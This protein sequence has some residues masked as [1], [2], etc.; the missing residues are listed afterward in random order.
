[1]S[2][3]SFLGRAYHRAR[4][5]CAHLSIDIWRHLTGRD[6]APAVAGFLVPGATPA[7]LGHAAGVTV[8]P[9]P[10]DPC[11]VLMRS[12]TREPHVAVFHRGR[13][14]HF[15]NNRRV[16]YQPLEVVTFGYSKVR[17]FTC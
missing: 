1:V 10:V 16:Q 3:D 17:F 9:R 11:F 14:M 2:L 7:L 5:N 12:R 13:V 4:Y 8:L 6:V 15:A